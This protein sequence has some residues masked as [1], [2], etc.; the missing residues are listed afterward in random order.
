MNLSITQRLLV[1]SAA[2]MLSL[3]LVSAAGYFAARAPQQSLTDFQTNIRP[4]LALLNEVE[5]DFLAIRRM[6][7][8]HV[9]DL[10]D[11]RKK[12]DEA[13]IRATN[14]RIEAN[15]ERYAKEMQV[16]AQDK[17]L[18]EDERQQIR[19]YAQVTEQV[20]QL[21]RDFDTDAARDLFTGKGVELGTKVSAAIKAHRE[22]N[23][24]LADESQLAAARKASLLLE[25]AWAVS[26]LAMAVTG[27]LAFLLIRSVRRSLHEVQE[28]VEH[29]ETRLDFTRR[30]RVLQQDELG[31]TAGAVNRLI[32]RMQGSL[33]TIANGAHSLA[34]SASQM[35]SA[36]SHVATGSQQQSAAASDMAATVEEMTVSINHVA[37]RAQEAN[38]LSSHSGL[39][40]AN[41][42]QVIG[43]TVCDINDIAGSVHEAA[44]RIHELER[45]SGEIA[46]V[47][48]VIKEVADQTNLLA[49]NAAIEAARAGEQGRGFAVVADEVR[50]LAE[51]TANSTREIEGTINTMRTSASGAV[52]CMQEAV[53]RVSTGV[54]G[55]Q[56]AN[57]AIQQ[58]RAGSHGAVQ[59]VEEIASAIREQGSAT[60]SIAAQVEKI[61][62]MSEESSASAEESASVAQQ[63]DHL[64]KEMHGIVSA[65]QL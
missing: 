24:K 63:L 21:S 61:A 5:R 18:L 41:G 37:D 10:Y 20:M 25:I 30:I 19:A 27:L 9:L 59:M 51:R 44:G 65:Y 1:M 64:A 33:Q 34:A 29:I 12:A 57:Q 15:L 2:S 45:H 48:A 11:E 35:A 54:S 46:S 55:A 16:D 62:Q 31:A 47:V 23:D 26:L 6:A 8:V 40:A 49:L 17:I 38:T 53:R 22:Y 36:A 3:L 42:E 56:E 58:I 7:A 13:N 32:E 39:L 28:A 60:N 43:Q 4:S 50:K 14:E 52:D